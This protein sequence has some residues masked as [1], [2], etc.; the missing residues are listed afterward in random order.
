P[1]IPPEIALSIV[2]LLDRGTQFSALRVCREWNLTLSRMVCST[3]YKTDW[4]L[5]ELPSRRTDQPIPPEKMGR[6]S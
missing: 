6:Y 5:P 1:Y 2:S 3:I 4:H